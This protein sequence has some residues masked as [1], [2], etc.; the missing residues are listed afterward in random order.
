MAKISTQ[1]TRK[2]KTNKPKE[3]ER[4]NEDKSKNL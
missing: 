1:E 4:V 2:I 3:A